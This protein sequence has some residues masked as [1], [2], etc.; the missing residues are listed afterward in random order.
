MKKLSIQRIKREGPVEGIF[1]T[2]VNLIPTI[3]ALCDAMNRTQS[4]DVYRE[5]FCGCGI[6]RSKH[7]TGGNGYC[8][9]RPSQ[10]YCNVEDCDLKGQPHGHGTGREGGA[11]GGSPGGGKREDIVYV[12]V[13][14]RS[15][16]DGTGGG[17]PGVGGW[18]TEARVDC[19][20]SGT[21]GTGLGR[22]KAENVER[23]G[24][25]LHFWTEAEAQAAL[26]LL[27]NL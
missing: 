21:G 5:Q 14:K 4:L 8:D 24:R 1:Y 17:T 11:N 19:A 13:P 12:K 26:E 20:G 27:L 25:T 23:D 16:D 18:N 15:K 9:I 7:G 10:S 6:E 22:F 3:Q 2:E